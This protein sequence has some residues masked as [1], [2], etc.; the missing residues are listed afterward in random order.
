M[1]GPSPVRISLRVKQPMW[2]AH[3]ACCSSVEGF[4]LLKAQHTASPLLQVRGWVMLLKLLC[5]CW[6]SALQLS[7]G[8]Q[9]LHSL[10]A[11]QSTRDTVE[12]PPLLLLPLL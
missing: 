5:L 3:V 7:Q 12:G 11:T 1:H 2:R 6:R 4:F 9:C 8:P 10:R